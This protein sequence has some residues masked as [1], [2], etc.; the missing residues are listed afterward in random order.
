MTR[1]DSSVRLMHHDQGRS[2]ITDPD[3]D[4]P[5]GMH[6]DVIIEISYYNHILV[7]YSFAKYVVIQKVHLFC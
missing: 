2:W 1:V 7:W 5:E 3:P 6:P 4:H